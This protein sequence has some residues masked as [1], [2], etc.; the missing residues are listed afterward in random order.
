[1]HKK[2]QSILSFIITNRSSIEH[3]L[4]HYK[5]LLCISLVYSFALFKL[6]FT[7]VT[8]EDVVRFETDI[9]GFS[10]IVCVGVLQRYST[11]TKHKQCNLTLVNMEY[12]ENKN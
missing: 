1:M 3:I 10:A 8:H 4:F 11:Y 9:R 6:E 7:L 12:N 2:S 5:K